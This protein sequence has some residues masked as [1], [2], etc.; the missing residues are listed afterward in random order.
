MRSDLANV[1]GFHLRLTYLMFAAG[2]FASNGICQTAYFADGYHGGVY[3][4]YPDG[5]T[6]FVVDG[7]KQHPRWKINLEIEPVTWDRVRTNDP[8]AYQE[9]KALA[10]DQSSRGRIEF[11]NPGYAQAYLWNISGESVI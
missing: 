9:F 10:A 6:R 4:H 2:C 7:L 3:G 8:G 11:V 5:Y 1:K